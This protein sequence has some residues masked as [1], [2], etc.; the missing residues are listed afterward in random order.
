LSEISCGYCNKKYD[1]TSSDI[2]TCPNCDDVFCNAY[3]CF[4]V[5]FVEDHAILSPLSEQDIKDL[6]ENEEENES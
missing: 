3:D 6:I 4:R 5:H 2:G 1:S